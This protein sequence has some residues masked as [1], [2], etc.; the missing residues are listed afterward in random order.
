V[1][2]GLASVPGKSAQA[3]APAAQGCA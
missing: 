1:R 2:R 3:E